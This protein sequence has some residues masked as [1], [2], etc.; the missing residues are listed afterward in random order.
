MTYFEDFWDPDK[1]M[2]TGGW[3]EVVPMMLVALENDETPIATRSC[4]CSELKR[5][6]KIVDEINEQK[7]T[8]AKGKND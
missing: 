6:A 5:L 3:G 7:F 4:I 2:E 8:S 1:R